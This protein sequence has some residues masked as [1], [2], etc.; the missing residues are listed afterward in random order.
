MNRDD[1]TRMAREA[2]IIDFRDASDDPHVAQMV[3]FLMRFAALVAAAER[4]KHQSDI[5]AWKAEAATAEKWR[6]LALC[7]DPM[8]PGKAVQEIQREAMEREREACA[9]ACD[10]LADAKEEERIA[11]RV[12]DVLQNGDEEDQL[13]AMRHHLTVS[14]FNVGIKK[15]AAA[16]RTRGTNDSNPHRPHAPHH[17]R[18]PRA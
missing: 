3:D 5:E 11:Q 18:A 8:Q 7:K 17:S 10:A 4:R 14:T 6:A 16:I 13:Q 2:E 12:N 15:C 9:S 1:V